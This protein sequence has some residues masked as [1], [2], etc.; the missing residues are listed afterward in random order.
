[1]GKLLKFIVV[2]VSLLAVSASPAHAKDSPTVPPLF[3]CSSFG[4]T[5]GG[6]QVWA[7]VAVCQ[8]N[9]S[10]TDLPSPEPWTQG[11]NQCLRLRYGAL[12]PGGFADVCV[13][14]GPTTIITCPSEFGGNML[15]AGVWVS[16]GLCQPELAPG[17]QP[18]IIPWQRGPISC[19]RVFYQ[20]VG[21]GFMD[22]CAG[23]V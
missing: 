12:G 13:G 16:V 10:G 3:P 5:W 22:V 8:P 14:T 1:M 19:W 20:P 9:P 18:T 6:T 7:S 21:P 15:G 4:G 23:L 17:G 11:P 2:G